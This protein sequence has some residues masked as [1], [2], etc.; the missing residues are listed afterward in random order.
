MRNDIKNETHNVSF[1]LLTM[2]KTLLLV[3]SLLVELMSSTWDVHFV[4]H[5]FWI[6]FKHWIK[7]YIAHV[8]LHRSYIFLRPWLY[9]TDCF[10]RRFGN[11]RDREIS[12]VVVV[13]CS[14]SSSILVLQV[15]LFMCDSCERSYS[16]GAGVRVC[17]RVRNVWHDGENNRHFCV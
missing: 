16:C 5:L 15:G 14:S 3:N 7:N 2:F 17:V 10:N 12:F 8:F 6:T 11:K 4:T 9:T 1:V 13:V